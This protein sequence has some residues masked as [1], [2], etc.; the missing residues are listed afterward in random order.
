VLCCG[1]V[2]VEELL[3]F[4]VLFCNVESE[5]RELISKYLQA[6]VLIPCIRP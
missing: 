3:T 2:R 4:F 1:C 6:P 5:G